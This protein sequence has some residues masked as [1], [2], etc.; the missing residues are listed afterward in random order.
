MHIYRY[1]RRYVWRYV[2]NISTVSVPGCLSLA[3]CACACACLCLL[4]HLVL[5]LFNHTLP[6]QEEGQSY[7]LLAVMPPLS[8]ARIRDG[9]VRR[10]A[11]EATACLVGVHIPRRL[12]CI[13]ERAAR[14]CHGDDPER[15]C[16]QIPPVQNEIYEWWR[17]QFTLAPARFSSHLISFFSLFQFFYVDRL[18]SGTSDRGCSVSFKARKVYIRALLLSIIAS[19]HISSLLSAKGTHGHVIRVDLRKGQLC[20]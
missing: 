3:V 2:A 17:M 7:S 20:G 4:L 12:P 13:S 19:C 6:P 9:K 5:V 16:S 15:R 11:N 18:W 14:R 1:V 8:F 10:Y